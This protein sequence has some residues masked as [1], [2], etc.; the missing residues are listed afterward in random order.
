MDVS[1]T[2]V[3]L[4]SKTMLPCLT[5]ADDKGSAFYALDDSGTLRRVSFPD[6]KEEWTQVLG[7]RCAWLSLSAEGLLITPAGGKEVWLIDPAKGEM[8][9]RFA[10]ARVKRAVSTAGSSFAVATAG[11]AL[12]VLDLKKGTSLKYDGPRPQR[13]GLDDPVLTPD[14]KYLFTAGRLGLGQMHRWAIIDG[15][16]GLEE[17]SGGVTQ[18]R[19]DSGITVSPD[20][21][22]VCF[23][24]YVGGGAQPP[25]N[26]TL[27]VFAVG[28]LK[29]PAF[30]LDPGGTA[31]GF[32]PAGGYIYAQNLRLF[33][34][35][36]KFLKEYRL[37]SGP[38]MITV[39]GQILVHPA[40]GTFLMIGD[41]NVLAVSVPKN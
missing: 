3:K 41:N 9:S 39:M 38:P 26:Y 24:S 30:V 20:S 18:G 10:I 6:L 7:E 32:D 21:K 40:G 27:S 33:D 16:L 1:V 17:S 4:P 14:G 37:G 22:W 35:G 34:Y 2:S 12:H 15:R 25:K 13:G 5:W 19:I 11:D 31:V 23:P 36:G 28:D 29:K 8:K